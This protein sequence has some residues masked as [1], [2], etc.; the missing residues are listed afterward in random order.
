MTINNMEEGYVAHTLGL[1]AAQTYWPY[2]CAHTGK[3]GP[4]VNIG[5]I[6]KRYDCPVDVRTGSVI[7][8]ATSSWPACTFKGTFD[9][10]ERCRCTKIH[11]PI[12]F[13][14]REKKGRRGFS[15]AEVISSNAVPAVGL[16][17]V[18]EKYC[19]LEWNWPYYDAP[20]TIQTARIDISN[21]DG[22]NTNWSFMKAAAAVLD[23]AVQEYAQRTDNTTRWQIG[24]NIRGDTINRDTIFIVGFIHLGKAKW[25]P[26]LQL[27]GIVIPF[28]AYHPTMPQVGPP[29]TWYADVLE[30]ER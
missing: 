27:D 10:I 28:T 5:N 1:K 29:I 2:L 6:D 7:P 19:D 13:C 22:Q 18:K 3:P 30:G 11:K 16:S 17:Q 26:I 4:E 21:A 8:A 20:G 12:F 9:M 15:I 25:R 23:R 14:A 24:Q